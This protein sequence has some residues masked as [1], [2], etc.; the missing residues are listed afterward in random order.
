MK[1][2]GNLNG[3]STGLAAMAMVDTSVSFLLAR[4]QVISLM[5]LCPSPNPGY[6]WKRVFL[7]GGKHR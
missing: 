6:V 3:S 1:I 4:Q 7:K 5:P 2:H